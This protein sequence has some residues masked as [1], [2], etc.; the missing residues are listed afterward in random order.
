MTTPV[1]PADHN[2]LLAMSRLMDL[3]D[4]HKA[5]V[6]ARLKCKCCDA[7]QLVEVLDVDADGRAYVQPVDRNDMPLEGTLVQYPMAEELVLE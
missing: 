3:I 7:E 5:R 6:V 1:T 2:R 4:A